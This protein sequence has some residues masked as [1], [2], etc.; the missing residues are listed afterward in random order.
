MPILYNNT[1]RCS[2]YV[3]LNKKCCKPCKPCC[4]PPPN[5]CKPCCKPCDPCHRRCHR[6]CDKYCYSS[7]N[8]QPIQECNFIYK[9]QLDY[10]FC[11]QVKNYC[12]SLCCNRN[13][14]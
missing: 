5:C 11:N 10:T 1:T 9:N 13:C 8:C 4:I 2:R 14:C 7:N 6:R 3:N 12:D